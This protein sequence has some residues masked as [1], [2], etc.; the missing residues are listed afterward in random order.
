[1]KLGFL[2]VCLIALF[3]IVNLALAAAPDD[4]LLKAAKKGDIAQLEALL[5]G[6]ANVNSADEKGRTALIEAAA[7]GQ[8]QAVKLLLQSG[9]KPNLQDK[10]SVTALLVATAK[11]HIETVRAL[12][13]AG[14]AVNFKHKAGLTAL[15]LAAG[16]GH[17]EVVRLLLAQ[18]AEIGAKSDLGFDALCYVSH[19]RYFAITR[20]RWRDGMPKHPDTIRVLLDAGASPAATLC[21]IDPDYLAKAPN[22]FAILPVED[23]RTADEKKSALELPAKLAEALVKEFKIRKYKVLPAVEAQKKLPAATGTNSEPHI[24][25]SVACAAVGT[26]AILQV[27][28]LA[29]KARSYGVVDVSG[30]AVATSLTDCKSSHILWKDWNVYGESRGFIIARFVS[31][32]RMIA[33]AMVTQL[34]RHPK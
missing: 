5:R 28:L 1:M 32:A 17:T 8:T 10:E 27:Q 6:G 33:S 30:I 19:D 13:A 7:E 11:G 14:A 31:G 20:G 18:G 23:L 24:E 26:D 12:L 25:A 34:P 3:F 2:F 22:S 15:M 29:S 9:A 16:Q 21:F 4:L